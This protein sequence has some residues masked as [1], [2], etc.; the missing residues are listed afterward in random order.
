MLTWRLHRAAGVRMR[1]D[2]T[3]ATDGVLVT[4]GL[5]VGPARLWGPCQVVWSANSPTLAGF[6]YGTLP[7]HPERGEEAFEV[8]RDDTGAVWF[9]VRAFSLPDRWFAA[10]RQ[11]RRSGRCSTRTPG[12]SAAPCVGS[13]PTAERRTAEAG[14]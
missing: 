12:G 13:A 7:G 2:A 5:G 1:T 11:A 4:A 3:R 8:A 9:E 10:R 6:G 14:Q